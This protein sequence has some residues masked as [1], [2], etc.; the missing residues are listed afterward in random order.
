MRVGEYLAAGPLL[1]HKF[2]IG[3]DTSR[4][5][6]VRQSMISALANLN[7]GVPELITIEN[8]TLSSGART[9]MFERAPLGACALVALEGTQT[10]TGVQVVRRSVLLET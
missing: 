4:I 7:T 5:T 8:R 2:E 3:V 6:L 1:E 9:Q 10:N